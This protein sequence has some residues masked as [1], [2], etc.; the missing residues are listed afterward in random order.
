[1]RK[2]GV[3]ENSLL[4]LAG[5]AASKAA[6]LAVIV[7]AARFLPVEEFAV[8]A[9]ALAVAG[10][11]GAALDFG[12]GTL[13]TRDGARG[14]LSRSAL[15]WAL[16]RARAPFAA[17]LL[18][19]A[20]LVGLAIGR[21]YA[22]LGVAALAVVGAVTVSLLGLCRSYQDVR[23]EALTKLIAAVLSVTAVTVMS[24]TVARADALLAVL[25]LCTVVALA[26][27]A[28]RLP[29]TEAAGRIGSLRALRRSAP[30]GLLALATIAYYRAGT[31]ALA[32]FSDAH[33]TAVFG[34]AA[35]IAF[36]LLM[37]PNAITT[38]LLP[39]LSST[40][41]VDDVVDFAR[42]TLA[43]TFGIALALAVAASVVVPL[44]LP[45]VLGPEYDGAGTPFALLCV[46]IPLIAVSGVIGTALL[47]VGRLRP[48][49]SQV[50]VSLCV[51]FA[52][53][54]VL[55]PSYGAVGGALA[56]V[57]CEAA[58]LVILAY[59]ARSALPGLLSPHRPPRRR[60]VEASGVLAP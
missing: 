37:L 15:F 4:V 43:W 53:L 54:A 46:G 45:L 3:V 60:R 13:L 5:D 12:A 55:V 19:A 8:F 17:V 2:R 33:Q 38:A 52:V 56:T 39:R 36:G 28:R 47:S 59:A 14:D 9:T 50:A 32:A 57:A 24:L 48:L 31:I 16:V 6:A 30:I 41:D 34:V 58:G 29:V 10:V 26:P 51:N 20:P 40:H 11:L 42:R 23:P 22:A 25:V 49:G 27:L 1:M 35:S 44:G 18:I 21:P 7:I